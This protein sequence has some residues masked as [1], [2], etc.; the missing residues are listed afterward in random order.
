M[1]FLWHPTTLLVEAHAV[2]IA[3]V[4][5]RV[6]MVRPVPSVALAWLFL[7]ALL[8]GLGLIGY[9][10]FGERRIGARR[11]R[12][13][14]QMRRP[15]EQR[16]REL[17]QR[18]SATPDWSRL[19][20]TCQALDR[21]GVTMTGIPTLGGNELQ[22]LTGAEAVLRAI[23]ADIDGARRSLHLQFYIWHPG[24]LADEVVDA[25]VRA[26]GR[27]V[28]C[29]VLVDALG[30][31]RWLKS[32]HPR[33]L[34]AAGVSVMAAMPTGPVRAL[35]RRND[36][37]NHRKIVVVDGEVAYTGSM[38]MVDPR[39]FHREKNVGLWVD[40]MVRMRG[41]AVEAL[42]S[43]L[44]SDWFLEAQ[45]EIDEL[46]GIAD[47]R[48]QAPAGGADVQVLASGPIAS[49]DAILQMLLLMLYGARHSIVITTPYFVPDE[50]MLRALRS[51][52][53]RGV[54]VTLIVPEKVDSVLVR[55]ASR[56]YYD[57]LM[58]V[59]VQIRAYR[60]GLLHTKSIVVDEKITMF[61]T[62]NLDMRSLWLNFEVSLFVY[63]AEFG[64][65]VHR[66][67]QEYLGDCVAIEPGQ[68]A[69]RR[70]PLR[71]GENLARLFSPLL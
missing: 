68:W 52:A 32:G 18:P 6:V 20:G 25:V 11:A 30:S 59:G 31:G 26:A 63:D 48:A 67:Q 56:S 50:A 57:D 61:G 38:N 5:L 43:V 42:H 1:G 58:A 24:G 45:Q 41:A 34:R 9:L 66:L 53:A 15:Y 51:A 36:L 35:F 37:R 22:L 16:Q 69:L 7:V 60:V 44:L 23:L 27:G 65:R 13:F 46:P 55:F 19:P 8:P 4:G 33:R 70:W 14:A 54:A 10:S 17:L 49:G 3:A 40:A 62:V 71:L 12:R 64:A 28:E 39:F 29:A 21:L 47:L 2:I